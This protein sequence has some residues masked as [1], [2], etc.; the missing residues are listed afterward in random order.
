MRVL[1]DLAEKQLQ[2]LDVLSKK[3][4]RSRAALVR[5]AVS[6]YLAHQAIDDGGDEA[7]GLWRGIAPDGLAYQE[8]L[9][10]E[11]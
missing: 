10:R 7:F 5:E 1:I 3:A 8:E 2:T 11:W 6:E 9:R 4:G